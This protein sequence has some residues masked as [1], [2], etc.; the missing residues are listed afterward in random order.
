MRSVAP[1]RTAKIGYIVVSAVLMIL[2]TMLIVNPMFSAAVVGTV[3]GVLMIAFGIFKLVGYFSKDLFRLAF[4]YDLA[5]GLL[6]IVLGFIVLVKP[7][8]VMTFLCVAIG[9]SVLADGL[10][11]I[12]IAADARR[13]GI[14]NWWLIMISAVLTGLVGLVLLF[15]PS[16]SS[17]ILIMI[18]GISVFA[19]GLMNLITVLL[20]VKIIKHQRSDMVETY[21][22]ESEREI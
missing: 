11:K 5:F 22:Y 8:H 16:G 1:M 10:F 6:L 4:Q 18:L 14:R 13:F 2:G 19:D 20:A 17:Q 15:E 21:Y 12:Q 3:A 7:E 9:I